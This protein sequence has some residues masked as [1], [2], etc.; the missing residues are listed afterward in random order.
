MNILVINGANLN[1]LGIREP[2]IY[3]TKTYGDLVRFIEDCAMEFS[4]KVSVE[5]YNGEG[6]IVTA[7]QNAYGVYDAIVI[8]AGGYTHTSV[9][10]LDALKAVDLPVAE[11]HLSDIQSREAFRKFSYISLVAEKTYCGFGFEG[12]RKAIKYLSKGRNLLDK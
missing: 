10:I 9:V 7:I 6:E 1:M 8:N 4:V 3:G 5:Q 11:V 12:Y 2:Q